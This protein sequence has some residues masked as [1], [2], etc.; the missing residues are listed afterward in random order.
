[1]NGGALWWVSV[2][3]K[4]DREVVIEAVTQHGLDHDFPVALQLLRSVPERMTILLDSLYHH[5]FV[6]PQL[7]GSEPKR[8][9]PLCR[10]E[11]CGICST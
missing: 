5:F 4:H 6:G 7:R 1:M 8:R 10:V 9:E 3:L 11:P 2:E